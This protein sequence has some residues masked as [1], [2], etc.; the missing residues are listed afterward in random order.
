MKL[1]VLALTA[2][3]A[4]AAGLMSQNNGRLASSTPKENFS[5]VSEITP[6]DVRKA[7]SLSR[8]RSECSMADIPA[9]DLFAGQIR[10]VLACPDGQVTVMESPI[11][12]FNPP[13]K[14]IQVTV[15]VSGPPGL[16]GRFG[17][18]S[19]PERST[20]AYRAMRPRPKMDSMAL[21]P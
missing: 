19:Q 16:A 14:D 1:S 12:A 20:I 6:D 3:L 17:E 11:M 10:E 21:I 18:T 5:D 4:A 15:V 7:Q 9:V 8:L 13:D 2:G